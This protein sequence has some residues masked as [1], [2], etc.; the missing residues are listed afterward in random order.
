MTDT[1]QATGGDLALGEPPVD[2]RTYN[3]LQAL[4]SSLEAIDAYEMYAGDDPGGV[5]EELQRDQQ[6]IAERLLTELRG[7]LAE[8]TAAAR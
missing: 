8:S 4:V 2:D 7:C 3:V 1:S 5:F 6:R